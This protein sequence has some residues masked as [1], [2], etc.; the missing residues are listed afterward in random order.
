MTDLD[1]SAQVAPDDG[2]ADVVAANRAY[3]STFRLQGLPAKAARGLAVVTCMDSRIEPL[4]MLG[5]SAGD[6]K[7][8]RNAGARVTDDVLRTLVLAVHLLGVRRVMVVAHTR[9]KMSEATDAEVHEVLARKGLDSRSLDFQMNPD[10]AA[11]LRADVQR[12][13]SWPFLHDDV[14]V[15]GFVYDVDTGLLRR[16]C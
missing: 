8:L 11:T 15:G 9:C 4:A 16:I 10:Q 13:D 2:F 12:I 14:V 3:A 6:A 5:I 7:I 1:R